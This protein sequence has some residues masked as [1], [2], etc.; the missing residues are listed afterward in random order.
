MDTNKGQITPERLEIIRERK[1][2]FLESNDLALLDD[3]DIKPEVAESWIRSRQMHVDPYHPEPQAWSEEE[4][5]NATIR[6]IPLL[7]A[8]QPLLSML[9]EAVDSE[10][11]LE[12]NR[13]QRDYYFA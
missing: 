11:L 3:L 10:Y 2:M 8:M 5:R 7:D 13:P 6:L 4:A 1:K 9:R 12:F